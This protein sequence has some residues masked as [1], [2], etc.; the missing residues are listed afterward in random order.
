MAELCGADARC[1]RTGAWPRWSRC[2]PIDELD[3]ALAAGAEDRGGQQPQPADAGGGRRTVASASPRGS[4]ATVTAVSES[5]LRT[6]GRSGPVL[7]RSG[8]RAFLIG[9][10][11][12][13]DAGS[14][15]AP[16]RASCA[17]CRDDASRCAA[18]RAWRT[19]RRPPRWACTRSASCSGRAARARSRLRQARGHHPASAAV[20]DP[21][22]GVR[23]SRRGR[24]SRECRDARHPGGA[25][26]GRGAA[27][28][29]GHGAAAS[30]HAVG[31]WRGITP[32][33]PGD[34]AVLLD[35]HDPV[36]RGGTGQTVDWRARVAH[37]AR[38]PG[39]SGRRADAR[40]RRRRDPRW[41]ARPAWTCRRA[42]SRRPGVKDH[43]A[44]WPRS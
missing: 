21:G 14:G 3:R 33:V 7:R 5:G 4:R 18:S 32:E 34:G 40:E 9:E 23:R 43:A 41:R 15:R 25:G 35:A 24:S 44:G 12:M 38:A 10:R 36:P 26:G 37:R 19:R 11:F 20:R 39:H 29:G 22:R 13:T 30:R 16:W 31:R 1:G 2:T 42:S 28:A 8:Y 17:R 27:A 6:A